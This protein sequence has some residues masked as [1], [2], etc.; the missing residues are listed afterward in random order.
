M[1][2]L[3]H[4]PL[5][6]LLEEM[7]GRGCGAFH[8]YL[9]AYP[10]APLPFRLAV[11][12]A[13][14]C[15]G[16]ELADAIRK[17]VPRP[18]S[19]EKRGLFLGLGALGHPAAE[20]YLTRVVREPSATDEAE[21][22]LRGLGRIGGRESL[23]VVVGCLDHPFLRPAAAEALSVHGDPGAV[24]PLLG[25]ADVLECFQ[26]LARI[27]APAAADAFVGGLTRDPP[28]AAVAAL[29]IGNLGDPSLAGRLVPLLAADD[30]G[31]GRAAFE[32]YAAL[33]APGGVEPL[34]ARARDRLEPWMVPALGKVDDP[35]VHRFLGGLLAERPPG[36]GWVK[37][38][39]RRKRRPAVDARAVY[40]AL[41]TARDGEVLALLAA[42][43]TAERDPAALRELL[44]VRA[45]R[46]DPRFGPD[47]TEKWRGA[48]L[49]PAYLVARA[50]LE[51]PTDAFLCDLLDRL[52]RPGLA[53]VDAAPD[54]ADEER[55]LEVHAAEANP[56]VLLGG[57]LDTDVVD[58]ARLEGLLRVRLA[59]GAFPPD[60]SP[61]Q[62][63][64]APAEGPLAAYLDALARAQ[65]GRTETLVR[66]WNL[67]ADVE[68]RGGDPVLD[69]FLCWEGGHRGGLQ[70]ALAQGFPHALG[71]WV[72]G[73]GDRH[74]PDLDRIAAHLPEEGALRPH[75]RDALHRARTALQS[76]CRDMVLMLEGSP[77][78]D[79]VMVEML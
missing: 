42:R 22:A 13:G 6:D 68:G 26:A 52:G 72:Q 3:V 69:L 1:D 17:W 28:W 10:A 60:L 23:P 35:G 57:F 40:R 29:G 19:A 7:L 63:F 47:L 62:R 31:V 8:R 15:L 39:F 43:V 44:E 76:E 53:A 24:E 11:V 2:D 56:F 74:L 48:D 66:L 50:L 45:F 4:R 78:G 77:R 67:L 51:Q 75:L 73:R 27:G 21:L 79:V 55:L 33:G 65:P 71:A 25:R 5:G 46:E 38:L 14:L 41:R 9:S 34:L 36:G 16:P 20:G 64:S 37:R 54:A 30:A 61:Q 32:A 58:P 18:E 59:K 12:T 49:L 70:R